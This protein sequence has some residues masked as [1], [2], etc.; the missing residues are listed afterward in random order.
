MGRWYPKDTEIEL[1]AFADADHAGCQDT[2]K[3][4]SRSV[5]FLG[6]KLVMEGFRATLKPPID[7][8]LRTNQKMI[9][10]TFFDVFEPS[11]EFGRGC[12]VFW[13]R[14]NGGN[15]SSRVEEKLG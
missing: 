8:T 7:Y 14:Y 13:E 4:T 10:N 15:S 3:S 6:E 1:T 5:L 2:R 9:R 12:V 11:S